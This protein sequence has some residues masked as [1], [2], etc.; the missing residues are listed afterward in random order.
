M[1]AIKHT[2]R[3]VLCAISAIALSAVML[4]SASC[5]RDSVKDDPKDTGKGTDTTAADKPE[6]KPNTKPDTTP[7]TS[8]PMDPEAGTVE[9]DSDPSNPPAGTESD[10]TA[11]FRFMR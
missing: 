9:P 11:R 1:K 7:G 4:A 6:T 2:R 8:H 10:T 5:T 3:Q